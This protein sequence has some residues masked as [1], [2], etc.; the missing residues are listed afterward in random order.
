MAAAVAVGRRL[1]VASAAV[2]SLVAL[3]LAFLVRLAIVAAPLLMA[4]IVTIAHRVVGF[5]GLRGALAAGV[6]IYERIPRLPSPQ[7]RSAR[8]S[9][10]PTRQQG[11]ADARGDD[12][13]A[14]GTAQA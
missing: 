3:A 1:P 7:R 12:G 14:A 9:R 8:Y 6:I 2:A 10:L 11:A 4:L 13:R 5:R